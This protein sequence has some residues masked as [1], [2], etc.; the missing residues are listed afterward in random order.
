MGGTLSII[1]LSLQS[2]LRY[3]KFRNLCSVLVND[4]IIIIIIMTK[5]S[6][7]GRDHEVIIII[8]CL[9]TIN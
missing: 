8:D 2:Y 1:G 3:L 7:E 6:C 5:W 9:V 4:A